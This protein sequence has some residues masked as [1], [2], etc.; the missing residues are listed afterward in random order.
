MPLA[1]SAGTAMTVFLVAVLVLGYLVLWALWHFV[2]R[3][4]DAG[5]PRPPPLTPPRP[6]AAAGDRAP[7][8]GRAVRRQRA[9]GGAQGRGARG[10]SGG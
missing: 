2:F 10:R 7:V 3:G 9:D 5:A 8:E 6:R 4:R 1:S